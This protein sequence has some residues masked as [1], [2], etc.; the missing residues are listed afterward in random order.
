MFT[1]PGIPVAWGIVD[2]E[3]IPTL[4]A[5]FKCIQERVPLAVVNTVMTD[6]DPLL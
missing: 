1:L 2:K 5:L 6:D 3:D 4:Q